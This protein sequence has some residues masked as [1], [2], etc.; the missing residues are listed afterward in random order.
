MAMSLFDKERITTTTAKAKE[1]RGVVERLI[2]Y[3][4]IGTLHAIRTAAKTINDKDILKKLFKETAP[5]YKDR[6]G[7]YTRVVKLKNRRGDNAELSIIELVGRGGSEVQRRRKK[8]S[9][10]KKAKP[11]AGVSQKE[12]SGEDGAQKDQASAKKKQE[13]PASDPK[14]DK[15]ES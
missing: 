6:Q 9:A 4:K 13:P 7:G 2:T 11:A 1:V 15:K 12:E 14:V 8:K 3:G 5:G 10:A